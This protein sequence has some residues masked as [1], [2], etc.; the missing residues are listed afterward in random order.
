MS[1]LEVVAAVAGIVSAFTG[2]TKLF[3]ERRDKRRERRKEKQN[4]AA[5]LLLRDGGPQVQSEYE[6]DF[7]R[8][9]DV[10]AKGDRMFATTDAASLT[11]KEKT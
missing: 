4:E 2:S 10:F 3:T 5:Q 1:G 8:L 6:R 9:G 7:A 11:V